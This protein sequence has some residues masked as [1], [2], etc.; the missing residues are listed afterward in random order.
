MVAVRM[1]HI[2]YIVPNKQCPL[3]HK[4]DVL[5]WLYSSKTLRS[6]LHLISPVLFVTLPTSSTGSYKLQDD[7]YHLFE[8]P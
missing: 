6:G 2:M 3:A 1:V 8:N 7:H 5:G 4:V